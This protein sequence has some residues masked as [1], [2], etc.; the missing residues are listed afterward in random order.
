MKSIVDIHAKRIT[1]DTIKT[2]LS[3]HP[4]RLEERCEM[5]NFG[6]AD[7]GNTPLMTAARAGNISVVVFL[8]SIGANV[9]ATKEVSL[10]LASKGHLIS[11]FNI[12]F[13]FLQINIF[14]PVRMGTLLCCWLRTQVIQKLFKCYS[15]VVPTSITTTLSVTMFFHFL[16]FKCVP[17]FVCYCFVFVSILPPRKS[18]FLLITC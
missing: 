4:L 12:D 2:E 17:D 16:V 15:A 10:L 9:E 14:G 3:L 11:V 8:L 6:D 5:R 1:L 18:L 7:V 13:C